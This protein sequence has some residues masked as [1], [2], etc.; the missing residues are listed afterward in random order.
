MQAP[1]TLALMI[2][3]ADQRVNA[4]NQMVLLAKIAHDFSGPRA[5]RFPCEPE[6]L[7]AD[8]LKEAT[9]I[10]DVCSRTERRGALEEYDTGPNRV[11]NFKGLYPGL[12]DFIRILERSEKPLRSALTGCRRRR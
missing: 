3:R 5:A 7:R 6:W 10:P 11:G 2:R 12:P 9:K 4:M 8:L 1:V